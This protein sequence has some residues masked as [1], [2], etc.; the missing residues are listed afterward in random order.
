[1][2]NKAP[3]RRANARPL[4]G[5]RL[6][7]KCDSTL[8]DKIARV[9]DYG[10]NESKFVRLSCELAISALLAGEVVYQNGKLVPAMLAPVTQAALAEATGTEG[11]R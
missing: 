1:M 3:R 7:G 6:V 9:R 4:K 5:D 10:M 11:A 2:K 8:K